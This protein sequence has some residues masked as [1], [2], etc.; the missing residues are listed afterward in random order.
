MRLSAIVLAGFAIAAIAV[1]F[2]AA[3][4]AA[5]APINITATA[6][7]KFSPDHV[8][9]HVGKSQTLRFTS[10]GGVHGVASKDLGIPATT[11]MPGTPVS[12][13]VTPK[14]A[15]TY[16][17]PCS[18]VCGPGHADMALTVVVKP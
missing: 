13:T 10:A 16:V 9:L 11:I 2:S 4:A 6:E 15:G 3:T 5:T 8:V 18:I 12:V 14:K 7:Q 1:P 17:I